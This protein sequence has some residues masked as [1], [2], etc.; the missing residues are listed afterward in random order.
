MSNLFNNNCYDN[1]F[2]QLV[3]SYIGKT[4]GLVLLIVGKFVRLR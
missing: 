4:N 3:Q 2:N 1:I